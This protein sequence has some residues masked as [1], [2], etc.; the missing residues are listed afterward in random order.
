MHFPMQNYCFQESDGQI[1]LELI[2]SEPVGFTTKLD[3]ICGDG[4]AT[5]GK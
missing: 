5:E 3:L 1:T 4:N 2:L